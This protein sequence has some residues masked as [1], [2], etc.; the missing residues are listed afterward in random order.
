MRPRTESNGH[1]LLRTELFYPLNYEGLCV[2][3]L[4]ITLIFCNE[5]ESVPTFEIVSNVNREL[6]ALKPMIEETLSDLR[7]NDVMLPRLHETLLETE[8]RE[9]E[10]PPIHKTMSVMDRAINIL[11]LNIPLA[12]SRALGFMVEG[13]DK[14][15]SDKIRKSVEEEVGKMRAFLKENIVADLP[16]YSAIR[17]GAVNVPKNPET[18]S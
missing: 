6:T 8:R 5:E 18:D 17:Y 15:S 7:R 9:S 12:A 13:D 14:E 11:E 10:N 16:N 3:M 4:V 2:I 1:P